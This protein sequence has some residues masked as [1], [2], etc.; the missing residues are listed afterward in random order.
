MSLPG[1]ERIPVHPAAGEDQLMLFSIAT[2]SLLFVLLFAR[3]GP[4][5][6]H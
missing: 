2:A 1:R 6:R 3:G 5:W 4:R